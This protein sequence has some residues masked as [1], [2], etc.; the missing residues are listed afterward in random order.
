[1]MS[2]VASL[3]LATVVPAA[4]PTLAS[5]SAAL[6]SAPAWQA[7]F[8]QRYVPAGF[9]TGT[10]DTGTV[11]AS[12]PGQVRFDYRDKEPRV[13]AFDGGVARMVDVGAGTCDAAR[14]D[15]GKVGSLPLA[16]LLDPQRADEDFTATPAEGEL[17]LV[18]RQPNPDV[19][20]IRL[21]TGPDGLPT[22]LT[23]V[24]SSDN[25]NEFTFSGWRRAAA[26]EPRTFRP[27]LPSQPP[28]APHD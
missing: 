12:A 23:I 17:R 13:F 19:R 27:S 14:L 21:R 16:A 2:L 4:S 5:V 25:R 6:R 28:C 3:A 10:A 24:D 20:E 7:R 18:P 15:G 22:M 8:E 9:D 1:M 26:P 11:L